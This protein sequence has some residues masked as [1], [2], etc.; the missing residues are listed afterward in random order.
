MIYMMKKLN[1]L[2][3]MLAE[4]NRELNKKIREKE[5]KWLKKDKGNRI[6]IK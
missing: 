6:E 3:G 1:S 5:E 4:N 2:K